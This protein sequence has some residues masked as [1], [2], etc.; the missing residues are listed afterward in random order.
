MFFL[1]LFFG[2]NLI[3]SVMREIEQRELIETQERELEVANKDQE[4]LLRFISHEIKGYLAKSESVFAE[5]AAGSFGE[6]SL[7]IK[8]VSEMALME[9]R[10]GVD[11]VMYILKASNFKSGSVTYEKT[12]FDFKEFVAA[13]F[14]SLRALAENK[15]LLLEFESGEGDYTYVGDKEKMREHVT[16]NLIDNAI[17]YTPRGYVRVFLARDG[18]IIRFAVRDSGIGITPEDMRI[19]FSQGGHGKN[20]IKV[21]VHSTGYGLFIAKQVVDAHGGK[22]WAESEMGKG[23]SFRFWVPRH[24]V[25]ESVEAKIFN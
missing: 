7:Q 15:G 11:M 2:L 8:E 4:S 16:R 21:N 25:A 24:A 6:P 14:E 20:S 10:K 18:N 19:L 3:Q 13:S 23:S 1:V 22:I 12:S 5:I 9:M 17:R